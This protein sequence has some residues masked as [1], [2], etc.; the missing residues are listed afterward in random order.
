MYGM[1]GRY[2]LDN[3]VMLC[4]SC[5][6]CFSKGQSP[7]QHDSQLTANAVLM[8]NSL[9]SIHLLHVVNTNASASHH[10]QVG[11]S[12]SANTVEPARLKSCLAHE[13]STIIYY[14]NSFKKLFFNLYLRYEKHMNT[15][16]ISTVSLDNF[17]K[18]FVLTVV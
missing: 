5:F 6:A 16:Y 9:T 14:S 13:L 7:I 18:A 10:H 11:M 1:L 3:I 17:C 8:Q 12:N 2:N 4:F 15:E